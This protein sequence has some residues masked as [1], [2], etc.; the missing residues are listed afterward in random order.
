M[1]NSGPP[2]PGSDLPP[3][4]GTKNGDADRPADLLPVLASADSSDRSGR[5]EA[6]E[7]RGSSNPGRILIAEDSEI[8]REYLVMVLRG[9]GYD[10]VSVQ[11]GKLALDL[12]LDPEADARLLVT[13]IQMPELDGYTLIKTVRNAD[14]IAL[15]PRI[16]IIA[17]TAYSL[18]EDTDSIIEMGADR[19][20]KKPVKNESLLTAVR[21]LVAAHP[22]FLPSSYLPRSDDP[23]D[24]E[25]VVRN[26][27]G[28]D[29]FLLK[30]I[31]LFLKNIPD[32][33]SRLNKAVESG[34]LEEVGNA[35]HTIAGSLG[36]LCARDCE[37]A[38]RNLMA[39]C[40]E[41]RS[42]DITGLNT[43]FMH[44]IVIFIQFLRIFA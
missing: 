22:R 23:L 32:K 39:A 34:N 6:G 27:N 42:A 17:L 25:E 13:D 40:R 14:G 9:K 37:K 2:P 30:S 19:I 41:G 12:L 5:P 44:K 21:E 26:F 38:A 35:A 1:M 4:P 43:L 24:V 33:I 10:T 31:R 11:N 7:S 28:N 18:D 16:P 20:V 15:D 8:T 29:E 36:I 3:V